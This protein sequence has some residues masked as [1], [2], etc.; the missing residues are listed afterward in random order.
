MLA[1]VLVVGLSL[2]YGARDMSLAAAAHGLFA[3]DPDSISDLAV[4]SRIPRT[5]AGL[6]VG[7]ALGLAGAVMQGV[8]RNPLAD[9]GLLGVNAG[10]ALFVV[11]AMTILGVT[12]VGGYIWF[13]FLGAAL[14]ALVVYSVAAIGRDGATPVKLA[15]TGAAVTAALGS[16]VSATLLTSADT[17][18]TFR[19][20]QVGSLAGR[21]D[22]AI[23]QVLPFLIVGGAIA[24]SSGRML[25]VLSLG[26]DVG[27]GLGQRVALSRATGGLA[28]VL[29]CGAA[30][31]LAGPIGFVGLVIP[32][33][34][35]L[36]SGADYRRILPLS[37]LLGPILLLS[38]DVLG[39][40]I[41]RPGELEVGIVTAVI[42]APVFILIVRFRRMARL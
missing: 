18:D 16:L 2:A 3:P 28:V 20:W 1:L 17:L 15:L 26:D 7:A 14:A 13:A 36:V 31:A 29:L 30:T 6:L 22:E 5:L 39:R 10:A 35:R 38:A 19:F 21:S 34:A 11:G 42:G 41:A 24:L 37:A 32:H 23:G 27:R 4:Q 12:S 8:A 9:P 25:N 40:L 33:V